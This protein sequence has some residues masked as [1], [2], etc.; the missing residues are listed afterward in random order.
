[1]SGST[2]VKPDR[3]SRI[4]SPLWVLSL[5]RERAVSDD[6]DLDTKIDEQIADGFLR[7][8]LSATRFRQ[9]IEIEILADGLPYFDLSIIEA[10]TS[11]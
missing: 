3:R 10:A 11:K 1:M 2:V 8:Q 6:F 7:D 9:E 4:A 5:L